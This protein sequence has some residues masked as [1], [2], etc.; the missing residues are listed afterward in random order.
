MFTPMPWDEARDGADDELAA[1]LRE[2]EAE[3]A[4]RAFAAE[5]AAERPGLAKTTPATVPA[6]AFK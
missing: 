4:E 6:I 2:L 1:E 3:A 5:L